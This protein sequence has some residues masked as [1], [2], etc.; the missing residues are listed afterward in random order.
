MNNIS[1]KNRIHDNMNTNMKDIR[2]SK[3]TII[4]LK[5]QSASE[6]N[7]KQIE[8]LKNIIKSREEDNNKLSQRLIDLENGLLDKELQDKLN[9]NKQQVQEKNDI[10]EKKK[11]KEKD[12]K[13]EKS[14]KSKNIY[15]N[16]IE[17]NKIHKNKDYEIKRSEKFFHYTCAEIP[18]YI[19]N[20]LSN[21]P[22]NKGYIWKG[23]HCYGKLPPERNQPKILFEK[24]RDLMIIHEWTDKFYNIYHKYGK[25][26][27]K[28]YKI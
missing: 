22:Y 23:I 25:E 9:Y 2:Y 15:K 16:D 11:Q 28:L 12:I 10:L 6:F 4:R 21:M 5:S 20:N 1:E 24:Q 7:V 18:G 27:K 8:K 17:N 14:I 13:N 26:N 19:L 3:K